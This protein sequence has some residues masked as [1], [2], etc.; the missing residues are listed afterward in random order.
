MSAE[1]EK[2]TPRQ[3]NFLVVDDQEVNR[4]LLVKLLTPIGFQVREAENG[5]AGLQVWQ[6]WQPQLIFMDMRM[7]VMDGYEATRQIKA[8]TRGQ[9]TII[10][11]LTASGLPGNIPRP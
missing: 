9:A 1:N 2:L 4:Q 7:P 5:K 8:T 10:I 3:M 11:A 6:D